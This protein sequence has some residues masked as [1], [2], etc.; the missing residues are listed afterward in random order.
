MQASY[1]VV[2]TN[3]TVYKGQAALIAIFLMLAISL[4]AVLGVAGIA[5]KER[6]AIAGTTKG[7]RAYFAA[8]AGVEDIFYRLKK[9]KQLGS[10]TTITLDGATVVTTMTAIG[11]QRQIKANGSYGDSLRSA[12]AVVSADPGASFAFALQAGSGG[13]TMGNNAAIIGNVYSEGSINGGNGTVITGWARISGAASTL[14]D[15]EVYGDAYAHTLDDAKVRG[16][17]YYQ[18]IDPYSFNWLNN[19]D[20]GT[21]HPGSP[22]PTTQPFP[23]T[24][25]QILAWKTIASTTKKTWCSSPYRPAANEVLSGLYECSISISETGRTVYFKHPVWIKGELNIGQSVSL[26]L[27]DPAAGS[28]SGVVIAGGNATSSAS[29]GTIS[30]G[31]NFHACGSLGYNIST[32]KCDS[33]NGSYAIF[34]STNSGSTPNPIALGQNPVGGVF[35]APYGRFHTGNNISVSAMAAKTLSLT[36]NASVKYDTGLA[37]LDFPEPVAGGTWNISSWEEIL[38]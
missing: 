21:A 2:D 23:V 15:I 13:L 12:R 35:F 16:D 20:G 33:S 5:L 22:D 27:L 3:K 10:E 25:E 18:V 4:A 17:A 37:F 36:Q 11:N 1:F 24:D 32:S 29:I 28:T 38:P 26:L 7:S 14:E 19:Y 6:A 9:N 30:A 31:N 8:E 34:I